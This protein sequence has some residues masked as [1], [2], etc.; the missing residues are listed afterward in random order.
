MSNAK[1]GHFK[2]EGDTVEEAAAHAWEN[3]RASGAKPGKYVVSKIEIETVNPIRTYIVT[4]GP[5]SG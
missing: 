1:E 4:I 5:P 2:G 3:A